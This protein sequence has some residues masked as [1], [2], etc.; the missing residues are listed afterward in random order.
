M[1]NNRIVRIQELLYTKSKNKKKAFLN[2]YEVKEILDVLNFL[3]TKYDKN[4]IT[5]SKNNF[6]K[7]LKEKEKLDNI[8]KQLIEENTIFK[9]KINDYNN[10]SKKEIEEIQLKIQNLYI[11]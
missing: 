8:N 7:V 1:D 11:K 2:I 10:Y 6:D 9:K 5:V 4:Q 3:A